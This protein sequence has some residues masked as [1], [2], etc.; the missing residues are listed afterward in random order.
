MV[1]ETITEAGDPKEAICE[2]VKKLNVNLLVV[3]SHG[4]GALQRCVL[5]FPSILFLVYFLS[6][7]SFFIV[8]HTLKLISV[9]EHS[10]ILLFLNCTNPWSYPSCC[11]KQYH[12]DWY[13]RCVN[14]FTH[15]IYFGQHKKFI[16]IL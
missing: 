13:S 7:A 11:S 10:L 9:D 4:K 8:G 2:A 6:L 1:A 15:Q 12:R 3:G 14:C 16:L 5:S